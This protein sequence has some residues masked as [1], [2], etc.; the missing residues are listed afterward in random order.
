MYTF[1]LPVTL[2][3]IVLSIGNTNQK[4]NSFKVKFIT[5]MHE[6]TGLFHILQAYTVN[7]TSKCKLMAS[8][9]T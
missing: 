5:N 3:L 2:S 4:V 6:L 7:L 8:F 1:I 9:N